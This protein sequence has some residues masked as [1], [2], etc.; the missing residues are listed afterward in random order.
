V[1]SP[2]AKTLL[3]IAQDQKTTVEW[4]L[5]GQDPSP[6]MNPYVRVQYRAFQGA[7]HRIGLSPATERLLLQVPANLFA[8]WSTLCSWPAE[9]HVPGPPDALHTKSFDVMWAAEKFVLQGWADLLNG[10]VVVY[11]APAVRR[12]LESLR[13][14]IAVAFQPVGIALL[15]QSACRDALEKHLDWFFKQGH[16]GTSRSAIHFDFPKLPPLGTAPRGGRP[17]K[18]GRPR[19]VSRQQGL[20]GGLARHVEP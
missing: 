4:L 19:K 1:R 3:R 7:V 11:G 16:G 17:A 18:R 12:K 5:E 10:L 6:L 2:R 9:G 14:E 8:A 20:T 15:R 13:D